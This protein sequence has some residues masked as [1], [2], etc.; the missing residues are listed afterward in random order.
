MTVPVAQAPVSHE[1]GS[2]RAPAG[3]RFA[4]ATLTLCERPHPQPSHR[5]RPSAG[6]VAG[7]EDKERPIPEAGKALV[8]ATGFSPGARAVRARGR[9]DPGGPGAG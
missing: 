4:G 1:R 9:G 3:P 6:S 2:R 7:G 5:A 8:Q